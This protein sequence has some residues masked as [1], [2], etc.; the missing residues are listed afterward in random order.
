MQLDLPRLA[1]TSCATSLLATALL[2]GATLAQNGSVATTF[3]SGNGQDGNMF[4]VKSTC[5]LTLNTFDVHF[6]DDFNPAPCGST[7]SVTE[8]EV[9]TAVGGWNPIQTNAGAWTLLG[10]VQHTTSWG[11][12]VP[13]PLNL[14]I[15]LSLDSITPK[16][17]FYVTN[18]GP[19]NS[20]TGLDNEFI[21]YTNATS[22]G[23]TFTN[24]DLQIIAGSGNA[25]PFGAVFT[26]RAW[27][28]AIHFTQNAGCTGCV[29]TPV[30]YCTAGASAS[31]CTPT[32]SAV[33]TPSPTK[34]EGFVVYV[35]DL[36][37]AKD[38]IFFY[39]QNGRQASPWGNGTSF[40]CVVPPVKRSGLRNGTGA[41]GTCEG[42]AQKDLNSFWCPTCPKGSNPP[43]VGLKMQIQFWYRD[44]QNTSNQTTSLS[45][46][47]EVDICP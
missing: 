45:D 23:Q 47:I 34:D 5:D 1:R 31:G 2:A 8:V 22:P 7:C 3:A 43:A 41:S 24:G 38:G 20:V 10:N 17:T 36:E 21:N 37:G 30:N 16:R 35:T 40:Q 12:K 32:L 46:A 19:I 39:G 14:P 33:G 9:Y 26:P 27:N 42:W 11:E 29:T 18:T 25:Y 6:A 13:Q 15:N 4:N 44:P 28:G